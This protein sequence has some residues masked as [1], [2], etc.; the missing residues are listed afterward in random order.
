[1]SINLVEGFNESG[2]ANENALWL[3]DRLYPLARAH[4]EYE[5]HDLMIPWHVRTADGAVDLLFR[6]LY[7]HREDH[8]FK[9]VV[10]HF[11]QPLGLFEGTVRVDGHTYSLSG[12]PG[13][14]E[15]QDM[16]W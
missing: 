1:V 5:R 9:V 14:T 11:A 15:D 4:F 16:L 6:P 2:P 8:D 10:S 12:V 3:G 13:V 7:V